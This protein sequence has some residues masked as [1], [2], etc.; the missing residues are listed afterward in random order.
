MYS[1]VGLAPHRHALPSLSPFISTRAARRFRVLL[2][3][4]ETRFNAL[5]AGP[6]RVTTCSVATLVGFCVRW[7]FLVE[8]VVPL[9]ELRF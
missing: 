3:R 2:S 9:L 1:P 4:Q 5:P 6:V 8:M 7:C